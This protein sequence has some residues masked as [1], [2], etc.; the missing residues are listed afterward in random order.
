MLSEVDSITSNLLLYGFFFFFEILVGF[1]V[2]NEFK[3]RFS[4]G[5]DAEPGR[6]KRTDGKK[7]RCSREVAPDQKYCERHMHRGRPRSR[8]PVEVQ[9]NNNSNNNNKRTRH[10]NHIATTLATTS[11]IISPSINNNQ[12]PQN[13]F[14]GLSAAATAALPYHPSP[15]FVDKSAFESVLTLSADKEGRLV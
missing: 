3:I 14:L 15:V 11:N 4:N 9:V 5:T 12:C 13:H 10:E 2:G 1:A 8:K 6:C 7:W